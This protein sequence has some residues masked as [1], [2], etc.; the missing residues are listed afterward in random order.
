MNL[1]RR[2]EVVPYSA[3]QMYELVNDIPAY[4]QFLPWC[5]SAVV[6]QAEPEEI[7]ATL[8]LAVAG[9]H[10]RF[11]TRNRLLPGQAI[12][13]QLVKGPFRH[14]SGRWQFE[15]LPPAAGR[16][17]ASSVSL[18][19][20]FDLESRLMQMVAGAALHR[21]ADGLVAAFRQRAEER[22]GPGR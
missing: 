21:V 16:D 17:A 7:V 20:D 15:N 5:R 3:Q 4:P 6:H 2:S 11:T 22:Y 9:F 18:A 19:I 12:E 14:F 1:V 10:K 8:E 13:L